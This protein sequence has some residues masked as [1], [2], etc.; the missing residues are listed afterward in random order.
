ME[1]YKNKKERSLQIREI[2]Q[3]ISNLGLSPQY[4]GI[5]QFYEI[6]R[7][8]INNDISES[9]KIKIKGTKR[10]LEYVLTRRKNIDCKVCL[11][12][13]EDV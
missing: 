2:I 1:K 7:N 4:P 10:I 3:E 5:K 11:K 13:R 6:C 12:Y 8:Y 9:G